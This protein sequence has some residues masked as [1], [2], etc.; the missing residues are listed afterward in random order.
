MQWRH[1]NPVT[2]CWL[3]SYP[4]GGGATT[5]RSE[6][7]PLGTEVGTG[8]P[9]V[10]YT[11]YQDM[12]GLESLYEERGNPF[13]P[14]GGCGTLDGMPISCSELR[15]RMQGGSVATE[16]EVPETRRTRAPTL[17]GG[18][19]GPYTTVMTR[20]PQPIFDFGVGIYMTLFPRIKN[21]PVAP[22]TNNEGSYPDWDARAIQVPQDFGRQ[23]VPLGNLQK[24]LEDLLKGDCGIFVQRLIDKANSLYG[25]GQPHGTSFWDLFSRIQD[26]GGYQL[27]DVTNGG[28]VG[29][30][31]FVGELVNPS[32][33]EDAQAGPGTVKITPFGP[34]GR[35]ARPAEVA[36]AQARYIFTALHETLHLGK[37]GWYYDKHLAR[38]G[39]AVDG[40][41]APEYGEYEDLSWSK[42]FDNVLH[43]H[44]AYPFK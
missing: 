27:V 14:G 16:F 29:G 1:V 7:D 22:G 10:S 9:Y 37:R 28:T 19:P 21:A 25:G 26:A 17:N 38:A 18:G 11:S 40:T 34:I 2:G 39:H 4:S 20:I 15:M 32:L 41:T 44:C 42:E 36:S 30:E 13:D 12:I 6:L 24:G 35:S 33:P 5:F 3:L 31:L 8:D 23:I 43:R